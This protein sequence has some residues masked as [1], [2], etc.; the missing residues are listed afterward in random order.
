MAKQPR[1][2]EIKM[3]LIESLVNAMFKFPEE[4]IGQLMSNC[5]AFWSDKYSNDLFYVEDKD[6]LSAL[7]DRL[8]NT[9]EK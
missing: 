8:D 5:M 9:I 6:L 4:R 2:L 3:E 1:D 7:K